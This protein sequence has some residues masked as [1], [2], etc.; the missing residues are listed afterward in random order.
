MGLA[1]DHRDASRRRLDLGFIDITC[2]GRLLNQYGRRGTL[3]LLVP[4]AR[5]RQIVLNC[6]ATWRRGLAICE[7]IQLSVVVVLIFVIEVGQLFKVDLVA[8]NGTYATE[9][10]DELVALAGPV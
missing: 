4:L 6:C 10:L 7:G 8:E 1:G 3:L 9:T 2:H 5:P